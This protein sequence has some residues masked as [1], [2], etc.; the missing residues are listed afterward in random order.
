MRN[1][2]SLFEMAFQPHGR[3]M[4]GDHW[5]SQTIS[6]RDKPHHRWGA[7][8]RKQNYTKKITHLQ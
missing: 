6:G 1:L 7:A 3:C 4:G 8:Q 2:Y 5:W